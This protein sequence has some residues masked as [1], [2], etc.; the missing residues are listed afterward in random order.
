[1]GSGVNA[2]IACVS[3][4][5]LTRIVHELSVVSRESLF[6]ANLT[7]HNPK[8]LCATAVPAVFVQDAS[9]FRT[10]DTAV[11]RWRIVWA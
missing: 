1:V 4:C 5:T 10:A 11:A 2:P 8:T 3:G 7:T 6:G 9:G